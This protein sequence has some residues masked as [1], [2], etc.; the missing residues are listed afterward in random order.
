[1]T[2]WE[3][4]TLTAWV[5]GAGQAVMDNMTDQELKDRITKLIRDMKNDQT[6]QPPS[7]II[8]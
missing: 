2:D 8:R 4:N 7:E 5:A 3:P 6:I 1:V